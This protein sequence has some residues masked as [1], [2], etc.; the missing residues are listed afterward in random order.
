[1]KVIVYG[2]EWCPW[3]HKVKDF[4]NTNKIKF[5]DRNVDEPKWAK[6]SFDKSG[7]TGIPVTDI[8]GNIVIGYDVPVLK[9]LLKL[10]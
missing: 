4:L 8:D 3:C 10:K 9:K 6:D 5:D 7:Q 1:M 2:A